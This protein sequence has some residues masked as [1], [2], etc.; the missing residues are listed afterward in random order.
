MKKNLSTSFAIILVLFVLVGT[1]VSQASFEEW[2]RADMQAFDEFTRA[3]E[4]AF[5]AYK[6][7]VEKKWREFQ[8]STQKEWVTY[9]SG[10]DSRARVDFEKGFIEVE[11]VVDAADPD[12]IIKAQEKIATHIEELM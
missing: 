11:A 10:K 6:A 9:G 2:A 7:D 5:N 3:E 12:A 4:A 1:A 8:E